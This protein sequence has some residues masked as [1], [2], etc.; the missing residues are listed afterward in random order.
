[1]KIV[2]VVASV[3]SEVKGCD[4]EIA[5]KIAYDT[6]PPE[7]NPDEEVP[8]EAIPGLRLMITAMSMKHMDRSALH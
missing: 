5:T 3:I 4:L 6:C 2:D 1:M 8:D 7:I